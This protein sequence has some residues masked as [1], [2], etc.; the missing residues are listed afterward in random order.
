MASVFARS[1]DNGTE[2]AFAA[3]TTRNSTEHLHEFMKFMEN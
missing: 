2:H 1:Y 3:R